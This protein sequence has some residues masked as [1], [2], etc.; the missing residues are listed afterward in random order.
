MFQPDRPFRICDLTQSYSAK[1]GGVRTFLTEKRR[2]ILEATNGEY[3]LV[4]PGERDR[5]TRQGRT[6]ICEIAS[7]RVP[8]SPNYRLLLRSG[9]VIAALRELQPDLIECHD[10]YNLPWAALAHR[11]KH[12]ATSVIAGYHTDFP[13]VYVEKYAR[14]FA[15]ATMASV[16]RQRSYAYAANLYRRFDGFYTLTDEARDLFLSL[17]VSRAR[18]L[19]LGAD[20]N[21]FHPDLRS[22]AL[23]HQWG[24][25]DQS[26]VVIYAGRIDREKKTRL[27]VEAFR[28]LPESWN[29]V[30][31][32]LGD[33]NER[34]RLM[35]ECE[36]LRVHFPGY[37]DSREALARNLASAD[38]YASGMEDE[39]FGISVIEA[40]AAGLP[41]AGVRAG[42]MIDRVPPGLGRLS[43]PGDAAGMA[44]NITALWMDRFSGAG[45]RAR[46]HV[47]E[48]FS[49]ESTFSALLSQI[50][51][52][53]VAARA[54]DQ[55]F[56]LNGTP[57]API[58]LPV[59]ST[60]GLKRA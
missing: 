60:P 36:G 47:M 38:I 9:A 5:M 25:D 24:A 14:P 28:K 3:F 41:V 46:A 35:R 53:A 44:Q 48:R 17:G 19:T 30:L 54:P 6:A 45:A 40:Q 39:T 8:G 7:P 21:C 22:S 42:A 55:A 18:R 11:R 26:P 59:A 51:A 50:Y 33:G 12:P 57:P 34:A 29:A 43:A 13:A 20:T 27:V 49:W 31:V 2:H 16:L 15:G 32:M 58:P 4:I 1:G 52:P 10:A 56:G 23:R 37:I